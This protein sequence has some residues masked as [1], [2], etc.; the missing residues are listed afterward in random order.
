V[1]VC[2]CVFLRCQTLCRPVRPEPEDL[3][4]LNRL[5]G[6]PVACTVARSLWLPLNVSTGAAS[7]SCTNLISLL[8]GSGP[9][10]QV[11]G[12]GVLSHRV[13]SRHVVL[14]GAPDVAFML[15][16]RGHREL[17]AVLQLHMLYQTPE[18]PQRAPSR[19]PTGLT[20]A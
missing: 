9:V 13:L 16:T 11:L 8:R 19:A 4:L 20:A 1:C 14:T 7:I 6:Q 12:H 17:L 18:C 15:G 10:E 5:V 3:S 2:V